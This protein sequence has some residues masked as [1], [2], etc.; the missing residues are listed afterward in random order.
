MGHA[1]ADSFNAN[2][3]IDDALFSN[4]ATMTASQIDTWL[5]TNFGSTSCISTSHGFSAPDP[6]GYSPSTGFAFGGNVSAGTVIYDAAQAYNINPQVI[7]ATLQKEQSLVSGGS[8]CSTLAYTAAAGYGCP[9]GG[10]TY[11]YSGVNLYT[12]NGVTTT[13]VSGT[14]VNSSLK[15]GF[16]QQVIRAAW[17]LKFGQERSEGNMSWAVVKGNWNN[18]DDPQSC[19]NGPMTQ[20]TYQI[21]PS[22]TT[23]Y[24]DGYTTIDGTSVHMDDGATAALYW[25]TPHFSGNQSFYSIFTGWFGSVHYSQPVSSLLV[26]G[27]QSDKI[28]FI[29]LNN[30]T[31]YF[32][33][34]WSTMRAFG[35]DRYQIV[36]M[37]DSLINTYTDG[38]TLKTLVW[39]N[40][41]QKIYMV[42]GSTKYW[43]QQ[44]C[45][46]WG[47]DCTNSTAG[48]VTFMTSSYFDDILNYGGTSSPIQKAGDTYRLMQNG[49]K[50]P[51]ADL[52]DMASMGYATSEAIQIQQ[53]D[54][55]SPQPLGPLQ[56][57]YPRFIQFSPSPLLFYYDGQNYHHVPSYDT[58]LAWGEP[59]ILS[60]PTSTLN[61]T[62]PTSTSDLSVWTQ[63]GSGH[64]YMMDSGRKIDISSSPTTWYSGSFQNF[65]TGILNSFPTTAQETNVS[66]GGG[67]YSIQGAAKRHVPS[68]DDYLWLGMQP[69]NTL[70]L[71]AGAAVNIP[72][73]VDVL[74]DG[75][76]FTVQGNSGLYMTN[77]S[78]SYHIP[79]SQLASDLTINWGNVRY[80]LDPTVLSQGYPSA[81]DMSRW[82]KS[83]GRS[84]GYL[85]NQTLVTVDPTAAT[86]WGIDTTNHASSSVDLAGLYN[87][88]S[89]QGLGQFVRDS[90]TGGVYYGTGGSYHY[91]ASYATIVALGGLKSPIINVY[92]DFFT[93][94]TQGTTYN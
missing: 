78:A 76:F 20:G 40:D 66:I 74:R 58:Y 6:T 39:N 32:V 53:P 34:T 70:Q 47:L 59:G 36:P 68:Y 67:V 71:A 15:A 55:N 56:I 62:P 41:D 77:G 65:S 31:R 44:Y 80:N 22:G 38:G 23:T 9:D 37:D 3:I 54:L 18:S 46:Q 43:F 33:P 93:G 29:S 16:S 24:Y 49:T 48:D 92:P 19:Y 45:A 60:P 5:N 69:S 42:D 72:S 13:S 87:V 2:N 7:L 91:V 21:C 83:P 84:L 14:C 1:A 50:E 17:L 79:S 30:N 11:S 26:V 4:S 63:D 35:L 12:I 85:S 73:G 88:P 10:T 8:G 27:N 81:G 52:P 28:Y 82:I 57:V 25:Y 94:L 90:T 61:S 89:M 86:N 51:F 75:A 64:Y